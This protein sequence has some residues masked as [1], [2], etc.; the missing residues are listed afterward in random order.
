MPVANLGAQIEALEAATRQLSAEQ[1]QLI[2]QDTWGHPYLVRGVAGSGKSLVMAYHV[3]WAVL[4]HQR[5]N[6]QLTL[7]A[8]DR[9]S[10]PRVAALCLNRS[11][12]PL[13]E[14]QIEDAYLELAGAPLPPGVV[15]INHLNGLFFELAREHDFFH[16]I[17]ANRAR[18]MGKLAGE[19]LAQLDAL[20]DSL[21]DRLRFDAMFI[22]EG[23]DLHPEIIL[24]LHALLRP[25]PTT[26]ERTLTIYY[27]DAQNIYGHQRPTWSH[28]GLN[29]E[30][31]RAAFMRTCYRNS[32]EVIEL[33]LNVLLGTAA[34]EKTRVQ[35][36][37]YADIYTLKE[38]G[39]VEE[40]PRGWRAYFAEPA[41]ELPQVRVFQ[42]RAEQTEWLAA[43]LVNLT[44]EEQVRPEDILV[45][46]RTGSAFPYLEET[47]RQFSEG[48]IA[49]RSVGRQTPRPRW[50]SRCSCPVTSL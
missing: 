49:L 47:V 8:A 4:R 26:T 31:G 32:R 27:D 22:D 33:G 21:L 13:L 36:R 9:H 43:A 34:D 10:M 18:E 45:L 38:K 3:A 29:V 12:I 40:T 11:F 24:L 46:A 41:G 23:Q 30:G 6:Q 15:T 25:D 7:F 20:S 39:L 37:R 5:K 42:N 28:F 16:Y 35:T 17:P 1:Q 14:R 19:Y 44:L 2:R 48:R 50:T